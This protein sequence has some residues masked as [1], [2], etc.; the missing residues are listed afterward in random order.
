MSLSIVISNRVTKFSGNIIKGIGYIFHFI[1]VGDI[2]MGGL[3]NIASESNTLFILIDVSIVCATYSVSGVSKK[4][5][6]NF[7]KS[8]LK[9]INQ[10]KQLK[11]IALEEK[12]E[13][14]IY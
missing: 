7:L 5:I 8:E 12:M 13:T 3:F 11:I 9:E 2:F 4:Y 14:E 6:D 10:N 1:F